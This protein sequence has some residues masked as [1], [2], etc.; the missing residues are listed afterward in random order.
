MRKRSITNSGNR[1]AQ[2]QLLDS[3]ALE[4]KA[5][6]I[7]F[8][9]K[10]ELLRLQQFFRLGDTWGLI[11]VPQEWLRSH[12]TEAR[13]KF[14]LIKQ[15]REHAASFE[16]A[17]L[18]YVTLLRM[19]LLCFCSESTSGTRHPVLLDINSITSYLITYWI[20]LVKEALRKP[21]R[22]DG[23]LF[24][25]LN[26][27]ELTFASDGRRSRTFVELRRFKAFA[28]RG[29]WCDLIAEPS[30][31]IAESTNRK[32]KR[33][34]R[35]K[36]LHDPYKPLPDKFILETGKRSVWIMQKL[37][38][39]ALRVYAHVL[40]LE[41]GV[42]PDT[43]G[44]LAKCYLNTLEWD[45]DGI[46]TSGD[47][48]INLI[49]KASHG[50]QWPPQ[51][52]DQLKVLLK[53]CQTA[54]YFI[55]VLSGGSRASEVLSAETDCLTESRQGIPLI[56]GKTYKLESRFE[57]E[58]RDWPMPAVAVQAVQFQIE[59]TKLLDQSMDE[60]TSRDW[61]SKS[62]WRV[63]AGK[64][65]G[66]DLNIQY[67]KYL[68]EFAVRVGTY[69]LLDSQ[70][71]TSHRFRKTIARLVALALVNAPKVL[72][73]IF[74]HKDIEMTMH[75][76]LTDKALRAEI[77]QIQKELLAMHVEKAIR[78][79]DKN[80]GP[81]A[82]KVRAEVQ[83]IKFVRARE[84][85]Q[86]DDVHELVLRMTSVG[87]EWTI[88]AAGVICTKMRDQVGPCAKGRSTPNPSK[89]SSRCDHRLEE[90]DA[91]GQVDTLLEYIVKNLQAAQAQNNFLTIDAFE[92][93]LLANIVRF[94][95]LYDKWSSHPIIAPVL[96]R[97]TKEA[98]YVN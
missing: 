56:N 38:P 14:N 20:P 18:A 93:Q 79:A 36:P 71:L 5:K 29:L 64:G 84:D 23:L 82:K 61:G 7:Q 12:E 92:G 15:L 40:N 47:W 50:V 41:E 74:G 26:V 48:Q 11:A 81:A 31:S 28:S 6:N 2:A 97:E 52:R 25:R 32:P 60:Y 69:Q 46:S 96:A 42:H 44:K 13:G 66:N 58:P 55:V 49:S 9:D 59:L 85:L 73:D 72:M 54:C 91:V 24:A 21:P 67:N 22:G 65:H 78:N 62:L 39:Q 27:N 37:M 76:I 77:M 94:D 68:R 70:A 88:V 80:G 17:D 87:R 90:A 35:T 10:V 34:P 19:V 1:R 95:A 86:A 33:L 57:G 16:E 83:R 30:V 45:L 43:A 53:V 63:F 75:Y 8:M 3:V 89:C 98:A 51:D 4:L